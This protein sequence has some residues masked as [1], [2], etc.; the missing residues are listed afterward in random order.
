MKTLK[1]ILQRKDGGAYSAVSLTVEIPENENIGKLL[2][3]AYIKLEK[4][5]EKL[6]WDADVDKKY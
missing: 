2:E 3:S 1:L 6:D 4:D 5:L